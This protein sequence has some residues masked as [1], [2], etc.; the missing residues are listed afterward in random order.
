M[1][2][3]ADLRRFEAKAGEPIEAVRAVMWQVK[4][5]Q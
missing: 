1:N 4:N 5:E 3:G 2:D